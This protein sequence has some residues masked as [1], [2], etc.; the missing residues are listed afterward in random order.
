MSARRS[1][2]GP[3]TP[4]EAEP[5][6][7]DLIEQMLA[8]ADATEV[9]EP[10]PARVEGV[11]IGTLVGFDEHGA[12]LVQARELA[13]EGGVAAR[14][15]VPLG[16]EHVGREVALMCEGG[17]RARPLV[18]GL[19]HRRRANV[20]QAEVDGERVEVAAEREIV[21]RCG[22]AS[23]TLT[24]DGKVLIK[25]VYVL[26]RAQTVNRIQGGSVKIN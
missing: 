17:D 25:G 16:E 13:R 20:A 5:E 7:A 4:A 6:D 15:V 26:T 10:P 3:G 1:P 9:A 21:L 22:D 23:I 19:L 12:P 24:R 11:L 14:S 2:E 18:M 8:E